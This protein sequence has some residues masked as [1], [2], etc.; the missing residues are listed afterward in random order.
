MLEKQFRN[1]L[2]GYQLYKRYKL[3][4]LFFVRWDKEKVQLLLNSYV[5]KN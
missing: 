2:N 4:K 3:V 1:Y 5:K